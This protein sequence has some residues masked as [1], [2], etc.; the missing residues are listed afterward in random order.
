MRRNPHILFCFIVTLLLGTIL[1]PAQAA[2]AEKTNVLFIIADDLNDWQGTYGDPHIKTPNMD[3]LAEDGLRL[4]RAYCQFPLC[5]PSRTSMMTGLYPDQTGCF[6][7]QYEFRTNYPDLVTMSQLF[8]NNGYF[9]A[10]V[11]KIYHYGVPKQIGTDGLDDPASWD[12]VVNP[13]GRDVA[14]EDKIFSMEEGKFGGTVSWLAAEGTDEEQTDGIG[15]TEMIKLLEQHQDEPFFLAMGFYR[16]HTPYVAPKKYFEL[17]PIDEIDVPN[18]DVEEVPIAAY[19]H[20]KKSSKAMNPQQRKECI[21]AYRASITFMD[22]QVG[23]VLDT[24]DRLGLRDNTIVVMTSDHGYHMGEHSIWQKRSLF[25]EAAR[26]PMIIAAPHMKAKGQ[27]SSRPAEL[28]DLYPTLA[29]LCD[30][31]IPEHVA[32]ISLKALLDDPQTPT[33]QAALTREIR[34]PRQLNWNSKDPMFPGHS[35][36]TER[37]RYTEWDRGQAGIELYDHQNDPAEMMNLAGTPENEGLQKELADLLDIRLKA[38]AA[39]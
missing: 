10:R 14:E 37:Y 31:P 4:D 29:E 12:H 3:A 39:L 20:N 28:I 6:T 16:P 36:R 17:Y 5:N 18:Q 26:V 8:K 35:I 34:D 9:T 21:Q 2:D 33:R 23:R 13:K 15:A 25:E 19:M 11:G 22:A 7:N 30:L 38:I 1:L 24:L 27:S 32:G